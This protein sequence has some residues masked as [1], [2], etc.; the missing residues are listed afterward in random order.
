MGFKNLIQN[1]S[2]STPEPEIEATP[3]VIH[4]P[5]KNNPNSQRPQSN[6]YLSSRTYSVPY[7]G[8]KNLGEV[9]P[10]KK[11]TPIYES[12]RNRSWQMY[13]ES[14]LFQTVVDRYMVWVIKNGLRLQAT[15]SFDALD[16][17]GI[18]GF[19][20][21][22]SKKIEVQFELWAESDESSANKQQS[23]NQLQA[24]IEK[25][26]IVGGDCLVIN[27][28]NGKNVTVQCIDGAHLPSNT[29]ETK[30]ANGNILKD[31]IE[32]DE[33]AAHVAYHVRTK[34]GI[35]QVAAYDKITGLR[36]AFMVNG[37]Q[38]RMDNLRGLPIIATAIENIK[39]T[40][41]YKEATVAQAEEI[42]KIAY[43]FEHDLNA[44]GESPLSEELGALG[45][46]DGDSED[47]AIKMFESGEQMAKNVF[48]STGR[49]SM[50]MYPGSTAKALENK[51]ELYFAPFYEALSESVAAL[52]NVPPNVAF[53][54]YNDSFSASRAATKDW[55][56]TM[57]FKRKRLDQQALG[58]IY[59]YWFYWKA[60]K[61]QI[62]AP[63]YISAVERG[64][65]EVAAAYTKHKFMGQGFP[66]ID[67]VKEA[68][69]SRLRLGTSFDHVP[70]SN[71][72][73]ETEKNMSGDYDVNIA[74]VAQELK[75]AEENGIIPKEAALD[76]GDEPVISD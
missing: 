50:N 45:L 29:I 11:F 63:G 65:W 24:V 66:H 59:S 3:E 70:L 57:D 76:T 55:E 15:P 52:L 54:K 7:D 36:Q 60:W 44:T 48:A 71:V 56:H 42:R 47:T 23:F 68:K 4:V 8:E 33:N 32:F 74:R 20:R 53:S 46:G 2:W 26:A 39:K 64:D 38:Y 30:L 12:L 14:D 41:R 43:I 40:D 21:A 9:G 25:N 17:Y 22:M 27:R 19:D 67:P 73:D 34:N 69:A 1:G 10:I 51:N 62:T 6:A 58:Y 37:L 35:V 13:L 16:V 75:L 28:W 49:R 31:G 72:Q 61:G 18:S 5:E